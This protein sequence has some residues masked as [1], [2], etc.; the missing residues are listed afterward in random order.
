MDIILIPKPYRNINAE[1][2]HTLEMALSGIT[3][4]HCM[5]L[6]KILYRDNPMVIYSKSI[7]YAV[8]EKHEDLIKLLS[9]FKEEDKF[10]LI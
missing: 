2:K 3:R 4:I 1:H 6:Q 5:D 10:P 9:Q 8:L 7:N